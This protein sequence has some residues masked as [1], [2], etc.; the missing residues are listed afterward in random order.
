MNPQRVA[1]VA[2]L[3]DGFD[4]LDMAAA[5]LLPP[6]LAV[7]PD[8]AT[9]HLHADDAGALDGHD[10]VDLMILEVVGDA[11]AGDDEVVLAELLDE[12]LPHLAFGVV[13]QAGVVGQGD[14]HSQRVPRTTVTWRRTSG[15]TSRSP[16]GGLPYPWGASRDAVDKLRL[17]GAPT[18]RSWVARMTKRPV[19]TGAGRSASEQE[20]QQLE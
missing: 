2:G 20:A 3:A 15:P 5:A 16:V 14:G 6:L 1:G 18:P 12:Q 17:D 7:M 13:G 10:E 11:L 4:L 8:L 19:P 9:L